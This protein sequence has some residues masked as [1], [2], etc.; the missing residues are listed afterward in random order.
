MV[1]RHVPETHFLEFKG[2]KIQNDAKAIRG[3][4]SQTISGFG[5]TEGGVIIWGIRASRIP[6]P[7]DKERRSDVANELEVIEQPT[8]FCQQL[9]DLLLEATVPHIAGVEIEAI[10]DPAANGSAGFVVC[11]VPEGNAKPYQAALHASKNYFQRVNDGFAVMPQS[12]LRSLF[13]PHRQSVLSI[14]IVPAIRNAR[15]GIVISFTGFIANAGASTAWEPWIVVKPSL[16][17]QPKNAFNFESHPSIF[18][19]ADAWEAF[20]SVHPGARIPAFQYMVELHAG[21]I[22]SVRFEIEMHAQHELAQEVSIELS[23]EDILS[24]RSREKQ[25]TVACK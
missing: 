5:N 21:R 23:V 20:Q 11:L 3:T 17:L 15:S 22:P 16:H 14:E 12:L 24:Q 7:V 19:G 1:A 25:A 8:A 10:N 4:W 6:N 18:P 13:F 2:G 9:R